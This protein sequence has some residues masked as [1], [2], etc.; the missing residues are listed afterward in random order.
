[1][2]KIIKRSIEIEEFIVAYLKEKGYT[3]VMDSEFHDKFTEKFGGRQIIYM[4]GACPNKT[5]M[6]WLKR[7]YDQRILSRGIISLY[8]HEQGFP[9]WVYGYSIRH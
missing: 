7:L 4:Y 2:Q 1:M 3:D 8:E 5:A 6:R 9:N